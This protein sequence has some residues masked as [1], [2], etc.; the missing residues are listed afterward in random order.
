MTAFAVRRAVASDVDRLADIECA[1]FATDRLTRASLARAVT[2]TA[3]C[4]LVAVRGGAVVGYALVNFRSNSLKARLFSLAAA[5]G[6]PKGCGR[7]LLQAAE[8]ECRARQRTSLRLEVR[9]TNA[10][11]IDLYERSGYRRIGR[12]DP[13]YEDGA[14]ALRFE[15]AF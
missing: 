5:P 8:D 3:S 7:A 9:E 13:Y 14:A 1:S 2:S 11:A 12:Y 10:R 6:T 15:K 4:L